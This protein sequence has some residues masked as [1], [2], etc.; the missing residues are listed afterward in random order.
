MLL[1]YFFI[2]SETL[3]HSPQYV[4]KKI[5]KYWKA[6]NK[7]KQKIAESWF[8]DQRNGL[9]QNWPSFVKDQL[10]NKLPER[11]DSEKRNIVFFNSSEHETLGV[12][13][14]ENPIFNYQNETI[15]YILQFQK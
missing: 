7:N 14:F 8:L 13:G 12:E 5:K 9:D 4:G 10:K 3:L 2:F 6:G 15:E 11:F 1:I